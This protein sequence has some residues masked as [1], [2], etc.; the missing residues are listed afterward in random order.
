MSD[1]QLSWRERNAIE[2][3]EESLKLDDP[4]FVA[5][6]TAEA[7]ALG[8]RRPR[9]RWTALLRWLRRQASPGG[10]T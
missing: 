4:A 3:L 5:C 8:H 10:D 7:Q 9:R 2:A 1:D 6:F